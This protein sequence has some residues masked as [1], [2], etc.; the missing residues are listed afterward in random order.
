M[1]YSPKILA[2][3]MR[4][5]AKFRGDFSRIVAYRGITLRFIPSLQATKSYKE[6]ALTYRAEWKTYNY[7]T[8]SNLYDMKFADKKIHK[9]PY[10]QKNRII[11]ETNIRDGPSEI[12]F[13]PEDLMNSELVQLARDLGNYSLEY[14]PDRL[15]TKNIMISS[16]GV[17]IAN[18]YHIPDSMLTPDFIIE[19]I[20]R[21]RDIVDYIP[22]SLITPEV[23]KAMFNMLL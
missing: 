3:H 14:I 23:K 10:H 8:R 2:N 9:I 16:V 21:V 19:L 7:R 18:F 4:L 15:K 11:I 12:G 1:I 17:N 20:S 6:I 5:P 22:R 13:I